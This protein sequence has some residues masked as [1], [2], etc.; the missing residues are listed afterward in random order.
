MGI[1]PCNVDGMKLNQRTGYLALNG[2]AT[3]SCSFKNVF[4]PDENIIS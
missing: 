4:I 1:V 3:Y 2:S